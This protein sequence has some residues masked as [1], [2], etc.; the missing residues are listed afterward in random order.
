MFIIKVLEIILFSIFVIFNQNNLVSNKV[1]VKSNSVDTK[2]QNQSYN[3]TD[4]T[5]KNI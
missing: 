5:K 3:K 4:E 1:M 2:T